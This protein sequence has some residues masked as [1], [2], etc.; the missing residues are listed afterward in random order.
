MPEFFIKLAFALAIDFVFTKNNKFFHKFQAA[1]KVPGGAH[2]VVATIAEALR[3]GKYVVKLDGENAF[4]TLLRDEV[5]KAIH[6]KELWS[7]RP[8]FQTIYDSP[9]ALLLYDESHSLAT[10]IPSDNGVFQGGTESTALFSLA[11]SDM[12]AAVSHASMILGDVDDMYLVIDTDDK[13]HQA[14]NEAEQYLLSKG[15]KLNRGKT[16]I[17]SPKD[18][19]VKI[20]EALGSFISGSHD[21]SLRQPILERIKK[22]AEFLIDCIN[23][24]PAQFA[25]VLFR[26]CVSTIWAHAITTSFDDLSNDIAEYADSL[27]LQY[28]SRI[29]EREGVDTTNLST[30]PLVFS[31]SGLGWR[32]FVEWAPLLRSNMRFTCRDYL[33]ETGLFDELPSSKLEVHQEENNVQKNFNKYFSVEFLNHAPSRAIHDM[34]DHQFITY[35]KTVLNIWSPEKF[36]C[37]HP[38]MNPRGDSIVDSFDYVH[39]ALNCPTCASAFRQSVHDQVND[40]FGRCLRSAGTNYYK[41]PKG[42]YKNRGKD[43]NFKGKKGPD[44]LLTHPAWKGLPSEKFLTDIT[45]VHQSAVAYGHHSLRDHILEAY[46]NKIDEYSD[47]RK[48]NPSYTIQPVVFSI[49]GVIEEKSKVFVQR[50]LK[51]HYLYSQFKESVRFTLA[52]AISDHF[53]LVR[54]R[55]SHTSPISA[56]QVPPHSPSS[57]ELSIGH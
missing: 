47:F 16:Q 5:K 24:L 41:E 2:N 54:A 44:G 42:F 38:T 40:Q 31:P 50:V 30:N 46:R 6:A 52:Q 34:N 8:L 12:S 49:F 36:D 17:F 51:F 32:K 39:H 33:K 27:Q 55:Y 15:I 25:F 9:G 56:S 20:F 29:L 7:L 18:F 35:L 57:V 3:K 13:V 21:L 1:V 4:N 14:I 37:K 45:I 53:D 28:L 19:N 11:V 43:I 48:D 10:V 23:Q 22:E 26:H